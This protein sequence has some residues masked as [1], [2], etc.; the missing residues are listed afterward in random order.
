MKLFTPYAFA[1][2]AK[3][4]TGTCR[5]TG[6]EYAHKL[7]S[8]TSTN[9]AFCV[10]AK[11]SPSWNTPVELPPSPIHVIATIFWPRYRPAI[12]TPVITGI[13]SPSIEIGETMCR[14]SKSPKWLLPSLPLAHPALGHFD[15]IGLV[16][17]HPGIH[18]L[19]RRG[20]HRDEADALA[21]ALQVVVA[22]LPL[23]AGRLDG[24]IR[25]GGVL[26]R[27]LGLG[28]RPGDDDEDQRR[29]DGPD[30]LDGGA[31]VELLRRMAARPAMGEAGVKHEAEHTDEDDDDQP[32][33]VLVQVV[34]LLRHRRG[35]RRE[36]PLERLCAGGGKRRG[37]A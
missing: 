15:Q 36:V 16:L 14:L 19:A 31:R 28:H 7:F 13:K 3:F 17:L 37:E 9:G 24:E 29:D 8:S 4:S 21:F 10:A 32:H 20:E 30:D 12:A 35:R 18:L 27:D 1:R 11:F 34:D 22:P 6:V 23:I 5:L 2:S 26:L 33:H 25:A